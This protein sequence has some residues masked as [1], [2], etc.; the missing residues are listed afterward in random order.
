MD[1]GKTFQVLDAWLKAGYRQVDC[2]T[3]YPLNKIPAD[4]RAAERLLAEYIYAHGIHDLQVTM[5]IGSLDNMR[6]PESNLA[7]SFLQ[8]M[9][10]EYH[11]MLGANLDCLMIHW[12]NRDTPKD[13]KETLT[14]LHQIQQDHDIRPGLSGIKH[15]GLYCAANEAWRLDFDIQ[16]KH[17]ILQSD[18]PR[19]QPFITEGRHRLFAYGI[20]AGGIKLEGSPYP[21]DSTFLARGGRPDVVN[22]TMQRIQE[23]LPGF[24]NTAGR[25]RIAT[26]NQ[27]GLIY[28]GLHPDIQGVLLG[29]SSVQQ[30]TESLEFWQEM[31]QDVFDD[32]YA[33]LVRG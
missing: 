18:L 6:S 24:N 33:G 11:R 3:N 7:P 22:D 14:M 5:K 10:E 12:D 19:Y 29:V 15:P 16:L 27:I 1:A 25:T 13:I 9:A 17:N 28:A 31:S 2:A 26:M 20:N 4:F 32:V 8:M 21:A 23:L 30:L